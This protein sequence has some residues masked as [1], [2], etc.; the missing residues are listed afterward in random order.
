LSV[1]IGVFIFKRNIT[2]MESTHKAVFFDRDGTINSD[3]GHYYIYKE[4]D[5]VFNP[6]VIENMKRLY[7]AGYILFVVTNQGGV[8]KGLYSCD[9]VEKLHSF[10]LEKLSAAG[11]Y[12]KDIFYCPHHESVK[13]CE[14]RKPS[15]YFINK[16]V[17][18]YQLDRDNCYFIG[19]GDRDIQ[20]AEAAG[21]IGYKIEKN[22]D[23]SYI[24]DKILK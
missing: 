15:P 21:I 11:V 23:F 10:M 13:K 2:E 9:D 1:K 20:A 18:E 24:I 16:A 19:D 6:K 22:T 7:D 4:E 8:A 12:I 17:E 3:I 5:F 14:C